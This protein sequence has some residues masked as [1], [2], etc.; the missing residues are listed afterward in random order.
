MNAGKTTTVA[1][2]IRG[3]TA[4]GYSIAAAKITGTA[5]SKDTWLMHDAGALGIF[6]FSDCGHPSTYLASLDDLKSIYRAL[7]SRMG[8]LNPELAIFEIADGLLQRETRM[9]LTDPEFR[10]EV[11]HVVFAGVDSL[12]V[13]SGVRILQSWGYNV[14]AVSG[15][16]S[17]SALGIQE[18]GAAAPGIPCL[19]AVQLATG[20]ILPRIGLEPRVKP[21]E[22]GP[23]AFASDSPNTASSARLEQI[24]GQ[25]PIRL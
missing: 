3:I 9:L 21:A 10:R 2:T 5:C 14:A 1:N 19:N 12:S 4:T 18:C 16:V 17:C 6:D 25:G 8:E 11:D 15:L 24:S 13:E 7:L 22:A 20:A 23:G